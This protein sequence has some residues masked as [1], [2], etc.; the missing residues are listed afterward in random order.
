M[1]VFCLRKFFLGFILFIIQNKTQ[2]GCT[3]T[4]GAVFFFFLI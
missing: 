4:Q 1:A 3:S 2:L